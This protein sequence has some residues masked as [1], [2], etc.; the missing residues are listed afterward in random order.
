MLPAVGTVRGIE[1]EGMCNHRHNDLRGNLY[2]SFDV[3]F[4]DS[5]VNEEDLAVSS[6]S[7]K[8]S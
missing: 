8:A 7:D 1:G 6:Q 4:P 3:E 5:F 2:F